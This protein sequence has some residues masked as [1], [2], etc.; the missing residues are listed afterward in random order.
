MWV[1]W[2]PKGRPGLR[3]TSRTFAKG[4]ITPCLPN[5]VHLVSVRRLPQRYT[6]QVTGSATLQD[7][8]A[9]EALPT[10]FN[11]RL[12][13]FRTRQPKDAW[14]LDELELVGNHRDIIKSIQD[15]TA[16]AISDG[17]FKGSRGAA[18][19]TIT[20][21]RTAAAYTGKHTVQGPSTANS[22]Y[23][24]ELSGLLGI[25]TLVD[26][27]C[28]HDDIQSG[29]VTI[30][31][32][33]LSALQQAFYEGP[34]VVT[35]PD[36]DLLHTL[37]H[38]LHSSQLKWT[39]RHVSGHQEDFKEWAELTWWEKQNV[40]MDHAAKDKMLRPWE[41]PSQHVSSHEG[42]SCWKGS[43][44]KTFY[45]H[46]GIYTM[47]GEQRV[48]DY[49]LRRGR[50]SSEAMDLVDWEVLAKACDAESPGRRR[51]V[52][53]HVTGVCGVGKFLQRWKSQEHSR[54]PRCDAANEDH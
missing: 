30:A 6:V 43:L 34:A 32:D 31:C 52:T 9:E 25:L 53:K 33:G 29:G 16:C 39:S 1:S 5:N 44:K 23:R 20:C 38:H 17:S 28:V 37:R 41:A 48:R 47:L 8:T 46:D 45:D 22:A 49:W 13:W 19:F 26:L 24:S 14:I 54:C 4:Q 11:D 2:Q 10:T 27:L 36:F 18:G 51:W 7:D 21:P 35:R 3:S 50:L 12:R 40:R 42:W 15:G